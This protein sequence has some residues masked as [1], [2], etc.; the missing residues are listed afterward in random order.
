MTRRRWITIG[1]VVLV[2]VGTALTVAAIGGS[3]GSDAPRGIIAAS[4]RVEARTVRISAAVGGRVLRLLVKEGDAVEAGQLLA[5]LDQR[6][7][8]AF[9]AGAQAAV[10]AAEENVV[11]ADRHLAALESQL[12]LA[13]TEAARYQRLYERDAAP[14]QAADRAEATLAQIENEVRAARATRSLGARQIDVARAQARVAVVQ[15]DETSVRS[16]ARGIVEHEL[17][18]EGEMV[19]PG[20]PLLV[21]RD[22][23]ETTVRVFLPVAEAQRVRPGNEVR[24]FTEAFPDRVFAGVVK[25]IASEAEFTP[26]DVHMPEDRATLVFAVDI[27]FANSDGTLKDGFP[28]DVHVRWD[29]RAPWPARRPWR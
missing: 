21:V 7:P 28:A 16:P 4:G 12:A 10:A 3:R 11:A 19:A 15:L 9:A 8:E 27:R 6:A 24:A 20:M 2:A 23:D 5:E 13:R 25:R 14:R 26:K 1:T 29:P 17:V 18:R 22:V